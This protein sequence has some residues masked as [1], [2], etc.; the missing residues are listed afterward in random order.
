MRTAAP[1]PRPLAPGQTQI[2]FTRTQLNLEV[3]RL[4]GHGL[5]PS[6]GIDLSATQA[7]KLV[8]GAVVQRDATASRV[9]H[10]EALRVPVCGESVCISNL[11]SAVDFVALQAEEAVGQGVVKG[12][13]AVSCR[14]HGEALLP[15]RI[16]NGVEFHPP[17][18]GVD[19]L[20]DQADEAPVSRR[21]Q[22][23]HA[24]VGEPPRVEAAV[25]A[26]RRWLR[27]S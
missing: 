14:N 17:F 5:G 21:V 16:R 18:S 3:L 15:P 23:D 12:K 26:V 7:D 24:P 6:L 20:A 2:V 27:N 19:L 13:L 22:D 9:D 4:V 8:V 10:N 11:G 25:A 1:P